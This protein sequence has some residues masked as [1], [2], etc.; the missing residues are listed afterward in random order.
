MVRAR[1]GGGG[2]RR[3]AGG[4]AAVGGGRGKEAAT[5]VVGNREWVLARAGRELTGREAHDPEGTARLGGRRASGWTRNGAVGLRRGAARGAGP[6]ARRR[7]GARPG[8]DGAAARPADLV[9][10]E[11]L[12]G[13]PRRDAGAGAAGLVGGPRGP[14]ARPP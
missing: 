6:G 11:H 12:V 9:V 8:G 10:E 2:G 7:G 13:R 14:R 3:G 1:S 5:A 4:G